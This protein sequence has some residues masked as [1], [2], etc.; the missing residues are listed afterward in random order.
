MT[1]AASMAHIVNQSRHVSLQSL[2]MDMVLESFPGEMS[3]RA[4]I[5]LEMKPIFSS[6]LGYA[7][8]GGVTLKDEFITQK[9]PFHYTHT[10]TCRA[11]EC[12]SALSLLGCATQGFRVA[13]S[14]EGVWT[15][16]ILKKMANFNH[17]RFEM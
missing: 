17:P 14:G 12:T 16:N 13:P 2:D 8:R 5:A 4:T 7:L 3:I 1:F 9:K 10:W 15:I 11:H 6:A